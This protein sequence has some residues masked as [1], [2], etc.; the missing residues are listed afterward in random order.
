MTER[1]CRSCEHYQPCPD[2]SRSTGQCGAAMSPMLGR[3]V[4]RTDY[5]DEFPTG[6]YLS[7]PVRVVAVTPETE[8]SR[9]ALLLSDGSVWSF[10]NESWRK[11]KLPPSCE[12][13]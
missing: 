13:G 3:R 7:E 5:T 6:C 10:V 4:E 8:Y 12:K 2:G 11:Q 9:L 1:R